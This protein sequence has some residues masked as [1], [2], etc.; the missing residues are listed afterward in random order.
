MIFLDTNV[1]SESLNIAP[2]PA[3]I[4]WLRQHDAQL[5]LSTVVIAEIAFGI[6]KIR[7]DERAKRLT[8]GLAEWRLRCRDRMFGF[9]EDTALVYGEVMGTAIRQGRQMA[10]AD[11]MIAAVA[12]L[13]G[14]RLAT[15]NVRDF[16]TCGLDL[17]NPW[18]F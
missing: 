7:P 16:A 5:A 1:V 9:T 18:Q 11:G 6:E 14:G 15:R 2:D 13:N 12:R 4:D 3:V 10:T 8:Q 17:I